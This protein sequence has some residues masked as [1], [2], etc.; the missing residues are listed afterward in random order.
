MTK[1]NSSSKQLGK[2]LFGNLITIALI[3]L[4]VWV[5][6]QFIPMKIKE[7]TM[8]TV[9]DKVEQRHHAT[10]YQNEADVWAIID[11]NLNINEMR[12]MRQYFRV[13]G[14]RGSYTVTVEYGQE[15]NLVV[16]SWDMDYKNQLI[17]N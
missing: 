8:N 7:G 11:K 2:S 10:P 5:G 15:L 4:G 13:Q 16:T 12:D 1:L 9:L 6:I 14:N 3:G 17:L